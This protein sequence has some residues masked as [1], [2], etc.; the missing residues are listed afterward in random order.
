MMDAYP[1]KELQIRYIKL[2]FT[3]TFTDDC[4]VPISKTSALRGGMGEMLLRANCIKNR[5]CETCDYKEECIVQRTMYSHFDH[6]PAF[7]TSGESIGYV[8]ECENYKDRMS[9]GEE[10][11]FHL[12]LFGKT[13]VYFNLYLQAI[14]ALGQNGLG[15]DKARFVISGIKNQYGQEILEGSNIYM[16]YYKPTTVSEYVDHRKKQLAGQS[17]TEIRFCTPLSLKYQGEFLKEFQMDALIKGI[18]RRIYILDCFENIDG[19]DLYK[20]ELVG[21]VILSQETRPISVRRFSNRKEQAMWLNGI[22][23]SI[24]IENLTEELLPIFL[25]GELIHVGKNTS[26]GFGRYRMEEKA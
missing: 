19:E 1:D 9:V 18:Q 23:G 17:I 14:A 26:F 12:I 15:K 22:K 6:K 8:I 16:Q 5:E 3:L 13:V 2:T 11:R 24:Q 20:A 7:I 21:P 25:A 4:Q 10:M